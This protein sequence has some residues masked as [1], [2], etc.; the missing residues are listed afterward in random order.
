MSIMIFNHNAGGAN[1]LAVK[2]KG[3]TVMPTA[4]LGILWVNT[5]TAI[6]K[7]TWDTAQPSSPAVGDIWV[8]TD[9]TSSKNISVI[10]LSTTVVRINV[11]RI[12]Q[13]TG[14]LWA[15]KAAYYHNGITWTQI[16]S[17]FSP[18]SDIT[19]TGSMTYIDDGNGHWRIK[20]LTSGTLTFLSV[21]I[22]TLDIFMVGGGA[23]GAGGVSGLHNFSGRGGGGGYTLTQRNVGGIQANVAYQVVV[24][25]GG[26]GSAVDGGNNPG[27]ASSIG[28]GGSV[29]G[30]ASIN[31]GSGGGC[32]MFHGV[33]GNG[34]SDGATAAN[35]TSAAGTHY[36]GVGQGSTTREFGAAGA[37]LYAGGGAGG[38]TMNDVGAPQAGGLGGDGGGAN[39]GA[40]AT[41]GSSAAANTGGGG[42]GGGAY[43]GRGGNGGA[44]IV[45][46]RDYRAA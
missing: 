14:T 42:G 9:A 36:G 19:Y 17:T 8:Q 44:G 43:S 20:F 35:K 5:S 25:A 38:G 40:D 1:A 21:P 26:L 46:I 2:V 12:K 15:T 32:Q 13:W 29:N 33:G 37:T 18:Q 39:G 11:L 28:F 34:A 30:G 3:G 10:E 23:G 4:E 24:G 27:G 22:T 31:G 16:S 45:V 41:D 7:S 6:T